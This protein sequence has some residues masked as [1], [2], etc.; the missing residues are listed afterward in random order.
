MY[1]Y[2]KML[3]PFIIIGPKVQPPQEIQMPQ[4]QL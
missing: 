2:I 1:T 3:S 4:M